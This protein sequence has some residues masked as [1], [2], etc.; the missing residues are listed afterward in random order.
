MTTRFNLQ[1]YTLSLGLVYIH[2]YWPHY[3]FIWRPFGWCLL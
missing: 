2:L 1:G 3:G